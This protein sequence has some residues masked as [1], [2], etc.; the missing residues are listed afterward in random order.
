MSVHRSAAHARRRFRFRSGRSFRALLSV[1]VVGLL[2][3]GGLATPAYAADTS[4]DF[5][6]T[7]DATQVGNDGDIFKTG[8]LV[9]YNLKISCLSL[10]TECGQGIITDTLSEYLDFVEVANPSGA[11][12]TTNYDAPSR[13]V[14]VTANDFQAG[15]TL[16]VV[17][18]TRV[19][20]AP[21]A[22][23]GGEVDADGYGLIRNSASAKPTDGDTVTS[24]PVTIRVPQPVPDWG[25]DKTQSHMT[26]GPDGAINYTVRATVP[27]G[28]T[29]GN[30]NVASYVLVDT[31]PAGA[32]VVDANGGTVDTV[33]HTITWNL[34]AINASALICDTVQG[35]CY[36]N[37]R[38]V[39]IQYPAGTFPAGTTLTN[40]ADITYTFVDG[41]TGT[42]NDDVVATV[43]EP[44]AGNTFG[45][46]GPATAAQGQRIRW[47]M[48][49]FN[50]G[51]QPVGTVIEDTLPVGSVGD[52]VLTTNHGGV[53]WRLETLKDGIWTQLFPAN[54]TWGTA[55]PTGGIA[56]GDAEKFRVTYEAV[57]SGAL[58]QLLL[59]GTV[60]DGANGDVF[61]NCA[62]STPAAGD[63]ITGCAN[64]TIST[65]A[66]QMRTV[67]VHK[68]NDSGASAI[69][70]GD[71][72]LWGV[73]TKYHGGAALDTAWVAD[74]LPAQFEYVET[75]CI[76]QVG[77]AGWSGTNNDAQAGF[78]T[79]SSAANCDPATAIT[80][81]VSATDN[82]TAGSTMLR[83][84]DVPVDPAKTTG[85]SNVTWVVFKV[86]VKAGAAVGSYT[87]T[88]WTGTDEATV[89]CVNGGTT[90]VSPFS[91]DVACKAADPVI[92]QESAVID[93]KKWDKG[94]LPNVL[95]STGESSDSCPDWDGFTRYPCV[96]QTPPNGTFEY[97]IDMTNLGN[98]TMTD[99]VMYDILPH[100]GDTGVSQ[101]LSGGS[102]GTQWTPVLTGPIVAEQEAA[103][104]NLVIEYNLTTNP[105]RPEV[106]SGG[107]DA[108]W[109]GSCD[110]NWLAAGDVTDWSAVKSFR[111]KSFQNGAAWAPGDR[112]ILRLVMQAPDDAEE[113]VKEPLDLSIAWNSAAHRVYR[114][115]A[116]SST[117]RLLAAEP[118]KVGI[119]VPFPGVSVGDYVW[120]DS[121]RDG[122]QDAGESGVPGVKVTLKNAA[123][124]V[125]GETETDANGYYYFQ[126]L[127]PN[128]QYTITFEKPA[129]LDYVYTTLNA[130]GKTD[131]SAT[132]DLND[133]DAV[134]DAGNPA[135]ATISFT[136]PTTGL[137]EIGPGKADNPGLDAGFVRASTPVSI[138]DYVW[139]DTDRDGQQ[140]A[141]EPVV[142]GMTVELWSTGTGAAQLTETTT[143][144]DGYYA[145]TDLEPS[146]DYVVKFIKLEGTSFTL[147]TTGAAATDSNA[148]R[149]TGEAPVT[150]PAD[151]E[152]SGEPG[153][154]DDPT[155]DA[156]L[157]K[158]NLVLK[159]ALVPGGPYLTGST[160]S[161]TLTPSNDG[162]VDALAGWSVK[163]LMPAELTLTGM[164]GTGYTCDVA[165][166]T[167]VN[168]AKLAAGA[169]AAP[170]T[171]TA[172]VT[173]TING[174]ARNVAYV[175]PA[176]TDVVETN[177]LGTP[178]TNSTDTVTST[179]DNDD[180][181]AITVASLVS[182]GDYVW[183]DVNRDGQ[184]TAG[185]DPV[186]GVTVKL[187]AENGTEPLKTTTTSSTGYYSFTGLTP[188]AEYRVEF[189]KPDGTLF[190]SSNT[191]ADASDSDPDAAG[192]VNV[193]APASGTNSGAPN[194]AD[195]PTID[196][197]LVK[198]NLVLA[199]SRTSTGPVYKGSTVTFQLV[200]SNEGPVNALAG[201]SVTDL[202]PEGMSLVSMTGTG[203]VCTGNSC[204]ANDPLAA[205]ASGAPITVTAK[206]DSAFVG[207]LV[208]V[209]YVAP[210]ANDIPETNPLVVPTPQ[211]RAT[212]AT[213]TA[214][215]STDNDAEAPVTTDSLVS[216]GDYVWYDHDRDG[217]QGG[218]RDLP[219]SGMT[220]NLYGASGTGAPLATIT[221]NGDGY[222]AFTDLVPGTKYVV[223]FVKDP[224]YS[225]TSQNMGSDDA[226]DSDADRT[227][228]RVSV[229]APASGSNSAE[230]GE[231]DDP[232][233]DAGI[234]RYN[235]S[236][237][238]TLVTDGKVYPGDTVAFELVVH[239][240]GPSDSLGNWS[241]TDLL[242][243][244]LTLTG[245]SGEGFECDL[246][247]ATCTSE[248]PLQAGEDAATI[249]VTATVDRGVKGELRNIAYVS[250]NPGDVVPED[251]PLEVPD[252][253]TDTGETPTDN[254]DEA[255]VTVT[256][257]VSVGDYVWMDIDRDGLQGEGEPPVAGVTV[258]LYAGDGSGEPI[259]TT[260]TDEN[261]F[262][263]FTDL[264]AG[265]KY[266]IE[267]VKPAD[268]AFTGRD[269]DD[270]ES[271]TAD[272]DADLVTGRVEFTPPLDGVNSALT[273]DDPTIDAGFVIYD[274]VLTKDLIGT[275]PFKAGQ[276]VTFE[277]TIRNDGPVDVLAGW[278]VAEELPKGLKLVSM[279]GD[280]YDC[281]GAECV[282][283]E[284]LAAG[285][286]A[287]KITVIAEVTSEVIGEVVNEAVVIASP[288]DA[289]EPNTDNNRDRA[290]L[291]VIPNPLVTTGGA[292]LG[293][294]APIAGG[295]A[296]LG[297]LLL[298]AGFVLSVRRRRHAG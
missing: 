250:P 225:F 138:G 136:S 125:V 223:E 293:A 62:T 92:I 239:N 75:M 199:K 88:S 5:T 151:G 9:R 1:A 166:A 86:R 80:P 219:V 258:N 226:V 248:D 273:P 84:D 234:A 222:Y 260:A 212:P 262:Y 10:T 22:A 224:A 156:G 119:I 47:N 113:S 240:D 58:A 289:P 228:G 202:L 99:H 230:P 131:N 78:N 59:D 132:E 14:T 200:P 268:H 231:A 91:D 27:I 81:T 161:Y 93:L 31:Y 69:K 121:D 33:N 257:L 167:C 19:K 116:D 205:G 181:A 8:G 54:G 50:S 235:L 53:N 283:Q 256:P 278:K 89:T 34:G 110:N 215:S 55:T 165:T 100:L 272:S 147:Q 274:L 13:T 51:N 109:Q 49:F 172:T 98:I 142:P 164:S 182:I 238:K 264:K 285:E 28:K 128:K 57:G 281:A 95:Q 149:S 236:I 12:I 171:V 204:V 282:A 261:G 220:V 42:A 187:F 227:T 206:V 253:D 152:N 158:Y 117:E 137:N 122:L 68:F 134:V 297:A 237:E 209:A 82:P 141:G 104:A 211:T 259:A 145:F 90:G 35:Y 2:A 292:D 188:G 277:L 291:T 103:G 43:E 180:E 36:T 245:M 60:L 179:T 32:V 108:N 279:S 288:D 146:T 126:Y 217:K 61:T 11:D 29:L 243:E 213:N 105:C 298:G 175:S 271:D 114:L 294:F 280:G 87:N 263:S 97:R 194:Q 229:T 77:D 118:L 3:F 251:N 287:A 269:A 41:T 246:E 154:A 189:V 252:S 63:S 176:P 203:Y 25:V 159:K 72:F 4:V 94:P 6:K 295:V 276:Q 190:T 173:S 96:A 37:A 177:P 21:S 157:L 163:E 64:T 135:I 144:D 46:Q 23:N 284:G 265:E 233:I 39:R 71:E 196:A 129:D 101:T 123:G 79:A 70:P 197:G 26:I 270:N 255:P 153:E 56:L 183:W 16:E 218:E 160:V 66:V 85:G 221:T 76:T 178:P 169:T 216:I 244:G 207:T 286:T 267:F 73:A 168:G 139:F 48:N 127:E 124:T 52:F 195:D 30:V 67:K 130:G 296:L 162:P 249:T 17:L 192:V 174:T 74:S 150:T 120:L 106:A 143:D 185:E 247:T 7:L 40:R 44:K 208:N 193:T 24:G 214:T 290:K 241:V 254:D 83:W 266:V 15:D 184:Q 107:S 155:I 186:T 133:S 45:K 232:T 210:S 140:D 38:S 112:T 20:T 102:R 242:P 115:N 111:V 18:V 170:I 275:S 65:P 201:W 198:Y 191:G 148:D